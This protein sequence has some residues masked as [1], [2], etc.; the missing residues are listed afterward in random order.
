M[1]ID[2]STPELEAALRSLFDRQERAIRPPQRAWQ[3]GSAIALV[4][5]DRARG[6]RRRSVGA[7]VAMAAAIAMIVGTAIAVGGRGSSGVRTGSGT[8]PGA[9]G[10]VHWATSTVTFDASAFSID[11]GGEQFTATVPNVSVHSDPGDPKYTTLEI[12]WLEHGVP[13]RWYVYFH[14]NGTSWWSDEMRTYDASAQG[15]WVYF[16]GDFFRSPL[17]TPFTGDLDLTASDHG[18]TS[19]LRVSGLRLQAFDLPAAARGT[20]APATQGSGT[21][22]RCQVGAANPPGCGG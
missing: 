9:T 15:D 10:L 16:S 3:A 20:N 14:S 17:G 5:L 19:H 21:R 4:D 6:R 11:V 13:M 22:A 1:S 18:V 12:E 2:T 7:L 8:R